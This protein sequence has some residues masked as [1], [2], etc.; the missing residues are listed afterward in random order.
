[1]LRPSPAKKPV[2][3]TNPT[4]NLETIEKVVFTREKTALVEEDFERKP[5]S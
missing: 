5:R 3:T 1:V 2:I 4:E